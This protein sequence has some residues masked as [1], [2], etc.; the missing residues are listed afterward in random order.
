MRCI[1][2]EVGL[3]AILRTEH[4]PSHIRMQAVSAYHEAK[5]TRLAA[6]ELNLHSV[7]MLLE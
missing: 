6:S 2:A 1:I 4:Q 3:K 5:S 7:G